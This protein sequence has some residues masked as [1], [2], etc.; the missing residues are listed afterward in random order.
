MLFF[1]FPNE[2]THERFPESLIKPKLSI[3][4]LGMIPTE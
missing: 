4:S 3:F 2:E 1:S